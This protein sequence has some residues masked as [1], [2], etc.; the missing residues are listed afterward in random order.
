MK[1]Y[2]FHELKERLKC[3]PTYESGMILSS[4]CTKP[5]KFA[6]SIFTKFIEKNVG[7]ATLF[8]KVFEMEK[9]VVKMIGDLLSNPHPSGHI[10]SGGSEGNLLALWVARKMKK[11]KNKVIIPKSAHVSLRRAIDILNLKLV[12]VNL[13]QNFQVNIN[14]VKRAIDDKTLALVGVAGSTDLG[15]IDPI[16]EL[17]ELASTHD[18]YLHVDA[19]FGGFVIPFLKELGYKVNDFDFRLKG[20]DSITIDPHKMGL[21]PIPA[22]GIIFRNESYLNLIKERIPY[23]AYGEFEYATITST[24]SGAAVLAVWALLKHFGFEGY[25]KIVRKC[26]RVTEALVEEINEIKGLALMTPPIMNIVGIRSENIDLH[27]IVNE[28]AKRGWFI[29]YL[30][31]HIRLVIMPHVKLWHIKRFCKD[32]KEIVKLHK[33]D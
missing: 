22:G 11:G 12:E 31:T 18:L 10:V 23:G 21:C 5:H 3:E 16:D 20:V 19:A 27:L 4:M 30:P 28:L 25:L 26:M 2:V 6:V 15:I 17:S 33:F 1:S 7:D 32:L 9:E 24:R 13:N 8:P 29:S 14:E